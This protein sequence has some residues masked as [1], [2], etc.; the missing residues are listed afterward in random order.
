MYERNYKHFEDLQDIKGDVYMNNHIDGF[1]GFL[2]YYFGKNTKL[3]MGIPGIV[4]WF[5]VIFLGIGGTTF[6]I[7]YYIQNVLLR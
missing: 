4:F 6:G 2:G 7:F 3:Y 5:L 1:R